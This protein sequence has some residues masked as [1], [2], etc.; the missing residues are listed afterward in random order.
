MNKEQSIEKIK[1]TLSEL[2]ELALSIRGKKTELKFE[3]FVTNEGPVLITNGGLE[4][5]L[6]VY[7][8]DSEGNQTPVNDGEFA[9]EGKKVTIE[10]GK[11]VKMEEIKEGTEIE[12]PEDNA[13]V[14]IDSETKVEEKMEEEK[15]KEDGEIGVDEVKPLDN[16][17]VEVEVEAPEKKEEISVED[18]IKGLEDAVSKILS[19]MDQMMTKTEE[20]MSQNVELEKKVQELSA[21]PGDEPVEVKLSKNTQDL[22]DVE[23][24]IQRFKNMAKGL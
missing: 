18:R 3:E 23:L 7:T 24:R 6:E 1:S 5:G 2:K 19:I 9:C 20:T 22:S 12:S 17:E 10:S 13:N 4:V 16:E 15:K 21:Q 11:I 8:K 14:N